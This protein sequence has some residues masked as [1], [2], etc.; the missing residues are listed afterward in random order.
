MKEDIMHKERLTIVKVGGAVLEDPQQCGSL[1]DAFAAI[2]GK[3]ILVHGGG[4]TASTIA[5]QLGIKTRMVDG[6]RITDA[7]MLLVAAMV[8]GGLV[9]RNIV[10]WLQALGVDAIGLTGADMDII[11]SHRRP[12]VNGIDYGYVGDIDHVDADRLSMLIDK[13]VVPVVAPLTHDGCGQL[14]NTNADTIASE[15]AAAMAQIYDVHLVYVFEKAGVLGNPDDEAS[16][17]PQIC[18][19]E[20]DG[21][22]AKGIISGGMIP[23]L[24]MAVQ[25]V[26]RGVEN[27]LITNISSLATLDGTR[28]IAG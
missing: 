1:L 25:A 6:R 17:I 19:S 13:G 11:R 23:K 21:L 27:V 16:V 8:Y 12:V 9:N 20:L 14:L 7:D 26:E 28:I 4:R 5:S 24:R 3:K 18:A 2:E 15:V 22:I 10:T